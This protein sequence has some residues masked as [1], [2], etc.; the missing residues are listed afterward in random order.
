MFTSSSSRVRR[1][2]LAVP[3]WSRLDL[4]RRVKT[5]LGLLAGAAVVLAI[6]Q[7]MSRPSSS[8]RSHPFALPGNLTYD[9]H[10][11]FTVEYTPQLQGQVSRPRLM[12]K[13]IL[14]TRGS[15]QAVV[16]AMAAADAARL[17]KEAEQPEDFDW[18]RG[19]TI[20][21]LG[22]S[23]DRYHAGTSTPCLDCIAPSRWLTAD[24]ARWLCFPRTVHLCQF[25]TPNSPLVPLAWPYDG[26]PDGVRTFVDIHPLTSPAYPAAL[27]DLEHDL[28]AKHR[29]GKPFATDTY[30][31]W[32]CRI[33][34]FDAVLVWAF[35][36]G[37]DDGTTTPGVQVYGKEQTEVVDGAS[38]GREGTWGSRARELPFGDRA[39]WSV[40]S[41]HFAPPLRPE[42][43]VRDLVLPFLANIGRDTVDMV[44]L[45]IGAWDEMMFKASRPSF[46]CRTGRVE[47]AEH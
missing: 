25:L 21:L 42:D 10:N 24:H 20:V 31:P 12:E 46:G 15:E 29:D 19:R 36:G 3:P 2:I 4:P 39:Y 1:P 34:E 26:T 38:I 6:I 16:D 23:L 32:V 8:H 9:S 47:S 14:R 18:L 44:E 5:A 28:A 11:P 33:E 17:E 7:L 41:E 43:R 30:R 45:G 13:L 40:D 37:L 35:I 27:R 22:D